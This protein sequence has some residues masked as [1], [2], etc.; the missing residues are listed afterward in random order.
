M[1][2][3]EDGMEED[4]KT[5]CLEED[6]GSEAAS[7]A[8]EDENESTTADEELA[9]EPK[10]GC[11]PSP[12]ML[13]REEVVVCVEEPD[14]GLEAVAED[15]VPDGRELAAVAPVD[16]R[17]LR[18]AGVRLRG[19]GLVGVAGVLLFWGVVMILREWLKSI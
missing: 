6:G 3:R 19:G 13:A 17:E 14:S 11:P 12:Q 15:G 2:E 7:E 10:M 8:K 1:G 5:V 18:V 9:D 4:V 16:A